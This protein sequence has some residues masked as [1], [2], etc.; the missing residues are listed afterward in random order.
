MRPWF[1]V[2]GRRGLRARMFHLFLPY[3][4]APDLFAVVHVAVATA[5]T[6]H[7]LLKKRDVRAAIAWIGPA[8]LSPLAG[9][10]RH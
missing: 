1:A 2:A 4:L 5:V 10:V 6:V 9:A 3:E 7:A 8:W